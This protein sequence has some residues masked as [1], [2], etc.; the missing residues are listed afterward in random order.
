ML[1]R[2]TLGTQKL[3]AAIAAHE[4]AVIGLRFATDHS[5]SVNFPVAQIAGAEWTFSAAG[6][7]EC[8]LRG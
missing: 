5:L 8:T 3:P 4:L 2:I 7:T 6:V 1:K